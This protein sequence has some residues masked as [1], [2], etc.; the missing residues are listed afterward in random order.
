MKKQLTILAVL[1]IGVIATL[2]VPTTTFAAGESFEFSGSSEA[3]GYGG[4]KIVASKSSSFSKSTTFTKVSESEAAKY[5]AKVSGYSVYYKT[6]SFNLT[7]AATMYPACK[8]D[9]AFIALKSDTA[10]KGILYPAPTNSSGTQTSCAQTMGMDFNNLGGTTGLTGENSIKPDSVWL[11]LIKGYADGLTSPL[12]SIKNQYYVSLKDKAPCSSQGC[13]D[14]TW[15]GWTGVCWQNART[16]AADA[17]RYAGQGGTAYDVDGGTKEAFANCLSKKTGGVIP[18]TAIKIAL[19]NVSVANVNTGGSNAAQEVK[20]AQAAAAADDGTPA[21]GTS[22]VIEGVGWIV[23]PI[24]NFLAGVSDASFSVVKNFLQVNVQLLDT[25][26]GTYA[27]WTTFRNLANVAFVIVFM[28]IIYSQL[29]GQGVSNYGVKKTLPRLVVAAILVNISFFV[30]Q[31]AVDV[32]QILGGSIVNV[33]NSIPVGAVDATVPSWTDVMGDV[34]MG[35]GIALLAG[36]AVGAAAATLTLS[37]SLP[38]L[39]AVLLAILMTVIILI[40]RQAAIVILIIL[41]PLAFVAFMLPNTE[42]W[43]KKWYRAFLALLMVYPIVALLYGGGALASR[44]ISGVANSSGTPGDMKFWLSITAIA[45][46]ALPL[47]MTP[48]LLKGALNGVGSLGTKLSGIANRANGNI[49]KSANTSSRYGEAKQGLKN[50]FALSR[51]N[52]RVNSKLQ[53]SIDQSKLGRA[54]GVD[55]GS[56]RALSIVNDEFEKQVKDAST[57]QSTLSLSQLKAIAT[58]G[59]HGGKKVSE[60]AHAAAVDKVMSAGGFNDRRAVL[61]SMASNKSSTSVE[62]RSRAVS[63]AYAKGDANIYGTSFGDKIVQRDGS[64]NSA[65]DLAAQTTAN[66]AAGS[67]SAE[68]LVQGE[69]SARYIVD[70]VLAS[71]D[72]AAHINVAAAASTAKQTASTIP[73]VTSAI[74]T[75]FTRLGTAA[76]PTTTAPAGTGA[77]MVA[78]TT[79]VPSSSSSSAPFVAGSNGSISIPH[80]NNNNGGTP[81]PTTP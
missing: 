21:E 27:A 42:K 52:R 50:R 9:P 53:Q 20:D 43:F 68:H 4:S 49:R 22:C 39:L 25:S 58:T 48:S 3:S 51:A 12:S 37:I 38:V 5:G 78:P 19:E 80:N 41:S 76:V 13:N 44:I 55:K 65:S 72:N 18:A 77:P 16:S 17:A 10:S 32:T 14:S 62:L 73:K 29:T 31:F 70:S 6:D 54:L 74:D 63:A 79:V 28:I 23:C 71:G 64:I 30:C 56:S 45:V 75:E 33:F 2:L 60:A 81:P 47:I 66:A 8:T 7:D 40:G 26:N 34:L 69:S 67:V 46:A 24:T 35:A 1:V 36:A 11:S 57:T 59:S 15:N 61:E